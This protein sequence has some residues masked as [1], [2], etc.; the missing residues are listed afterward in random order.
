[1]R[2]LQYE[3][4]HW[5]QIAG[6][7]VDHLQHFSRCGLLLQRLPLFGDQPGVL[8]GDDR[9]VGKGADEFDL[10]VGK[11]F[12]PLAGEDDYTDRFVFAQQG[13][14]KCRPHVPQFYGRFGISWNGGRIVNMHGATFTGGPCQD[15]GRVRINKRN[16]P[17]GVEISLVLRWK[18]KI[19]R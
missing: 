5:H 17:L 3:L 2:L 15:S 11:W 16:Q 6:R 9:L 19:C 7:C 1:M 18:S 13:Y 4:E 8:D 12:D 14:S 10:A